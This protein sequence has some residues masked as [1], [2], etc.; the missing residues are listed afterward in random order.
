MHGPKK[1]FHKYLAAGGRKQKINAH[2]IFTSKTLCCYIEKKKQYLFKDIKNV[3]V[4]QMS[5]NQN[6]SVKWGEDCISW[7]LYLEKSEEHNLVEKAKH[8]LSQNLNLH[9]WFPGILDRIN[10][11]A[12][13]ITDTWPPTN[14][15]KSKS[16]A[17]HSPRTPL[18]NRVTTSP[19]WLVSSWKVINVKWDIRY[20]LK[21]TCTPNFKDLGQKK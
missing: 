18:F 2:L 3:K 6:T 1:M 7:V 9:I 21:V 16:N 19:M 4:F 17:I 20:A 12:L 10:L 8:Q 15:V 5:I 11:G 14:A 13:R